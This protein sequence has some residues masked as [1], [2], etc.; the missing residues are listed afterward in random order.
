MTYKQDLLN[1]Q[2][3]MYESHKPN[4]ES[5]LEVFQEL[6]EEIDTID[7]RISNN[8]SDETLDV[9]NEFNK[10]WF[11]DSIDLKDQYNYR[12]LIEDTDKHLKSFKDER[13]RK[14]KEYIDKY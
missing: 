1:N 10:T 8:D 5:F 13:T 14:I 12:Q 2:I 7:K 9:L 3:D 6:S 4:D 11:P